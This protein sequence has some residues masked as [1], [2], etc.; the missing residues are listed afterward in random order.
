MQYRYCEFHLSCQIWQEFSPLNLFLNSSYVIASFYIVYLLCGFLGILT[1]K[2]LGCFFIRVISGLCYMLQLV[3]YLMLACTKS[4]ANDF[5]LH[6]LYIKTRM[7]KQF[8]H[9]CVQDCM[10]HFI[11]SLQAR[12]LTQACIV[13]QGLLASLLCIRFQQ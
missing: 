2:K 4:W 6:S 1:G 3:S 9:A 11:T 10:Y 13:M 5:L 7:F 12:K 8:T